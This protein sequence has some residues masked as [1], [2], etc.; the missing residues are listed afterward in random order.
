MAARAGD[1]QVIGGR[2]LSHIECNPGDLE[3]T[4]VMK[5]TY[6]LLAIKAAS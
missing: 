6:W 5:E 4:S 1:G 3:E 2:L